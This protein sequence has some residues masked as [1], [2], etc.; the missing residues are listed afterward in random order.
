MDIQN[1]RILDGLNFIASNV[2]VAGQSNK[3]AL[4]DVS[5]KIQENADNIKQAG[6]DNK[7]GLGLLGSHTETAASNIDKLATNVATAGTE[8]KNSLNALAG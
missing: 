7:D 8:N 4:A 6:T 3:E 5:L 1:E 2:Q